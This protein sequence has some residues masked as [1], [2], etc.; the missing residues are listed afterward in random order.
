[1]YIYR[2]CC[3]NV[4]VVAVAVAAVVALVAVFAVVAV[5]VFSFFPLRQKR[6]V[7]HA[8][9]QCNYGKQRRNREGLLKYKIARG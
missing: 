1:M 2:H 5:Y 6:S 4:F 7:R 8:M 9:E 3:I